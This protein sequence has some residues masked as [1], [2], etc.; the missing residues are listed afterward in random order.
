MNSIN[1]LNQWLNNPSNVYIGLFTHGIIDG[2][3]IDNP[4]K[5]FYRVFDGCQMQDTETLMETFQRVMPF[6]NGFGKNYY[7]LCDCLCLDIHWE[8]N[9]QARPPV[10]TPEKIVLVVKNAE[11]LLKK[12]IHDKLFFLQTIVQAGEYWLSETPDPDIDYNNLENVDVNRLIDAHKTTPFRLLLGCSTNKLLY[13]VRASIDNLFKNAPCDK[14]RPV[15]YIYCHDVNATYTMKQI[16]SPVHGS[17]YY[18]ISSSAFK[19]AYQISNRDGEIIYNIKSFIKLPNAPANL[20]GCKIE[21]LVSGQLVY[22][23]QNLFPNKKYPNGFYDSNWNPIAIRNKTYFEDVPMD[24]KNRK[25][26]I[27]SIDGLSDE[28][29]QTIDFYSSD[30]SGLNSLFKKYPGEMLR[31]LVIPQGEC[32]Y[33][34]GDFP[35]RWTCKKIVVVRDCKGQKVLHLIRNSN[36]SYNSPIPIRISRP[37]DNAD[38]ELVLLFS[39]LTALTTRPELDN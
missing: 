27:Q 35:Q 39:A 16:S 18:A 36:K 15:S 33:L 6:F 22:Y 31:S 13:Q 28:A 11:F 8:E 17:R 29:L 12:T 14:Y 20:G 21:N 38:I 24:S 5:T 4:D 7:A 25:A 37:I 3:T 32:P 2:L 1:S 23:V 26:L 9:L 30:F 34:I 10:V 19:F